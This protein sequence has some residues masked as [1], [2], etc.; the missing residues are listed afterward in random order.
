MP[1]RAL[2]FNSQ[3][4]SIFHREVREMCICRK[5]TK[6][7]LRENDSYAVT[8][9]NYKFDSIARRDSVNLALLNETAHVSDINCA[10]AT[11]SCAANA[12][13]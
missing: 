3:Q 10:D 13:R 2:R 6:I 8:T 5:I 12:V 9:F 1:L 4:K 11:A 7:R